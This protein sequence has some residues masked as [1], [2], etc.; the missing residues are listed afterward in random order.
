MVRTDATADDSLAAMRARRRFGIAIAAMIRMIATTI[1]NSISEK[2]FCFFIFSLGCFQ[3]AIDFLAQLSAGF[4]NP[5]VRMQQA[6][7]RAQQGAT[8]NC[9]PS[10]GGLAA[11]KCRS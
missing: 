8:R 6:T 2:P 4:F 9:N 10:L 3:P 5:T 11:E 1:N 7:F